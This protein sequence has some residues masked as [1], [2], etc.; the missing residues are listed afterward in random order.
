VSEHGVFVDGAAITKRAV[1]TK[2]GFLPIHGTSLALGGM[3]RGVDMNISVEPVTGGWASAD[4]AVA[5]MTNALSVDVED[6][7]QVS[8]FE[9]Q[10]SR[11]QWERLPCRVERNVDR[12][13]A[14]LD[15][16]GARAT[17]FTLGWVAKRYPQLVRRIAD[18][19]HEVASHGFS[20]RRATDQAPHAFYEDIVAAKRVLEDIVGHAV[21]GYRAPSFSI[22]GRNLWAFDCIA[23]AGYRYSSSVYPVRHDH[24]GMPDAP[25]HMHRLSN[26]L[27][28]VPLTTAQVFGVNLPAAGGG[29]FRLAPYA[30]SRWAILRVNQLERR[31]AV[32]Y[33]HPW[34]IDPE[35]PR[36]EGASLKSRFRHYLN[37]GR[38]AAR[39]DR[40]LADFRWDRIDRTFELSFE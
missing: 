25:R 4:D 13:L 39:L 6:Y 16:R 40:L 8:A 11:A 14:M 5:Q 7:F 29:Y 31:P 34:E 3:Q 26:G 36:V 28:E 17:F 1:V 20:H 24:Y 37:L 21:H 18:A 12:L 2:K 9:Q 10:V 32:F 30:L 35:Q 19:K 38:T 23:R 15:A 22:S 27:I 33:M